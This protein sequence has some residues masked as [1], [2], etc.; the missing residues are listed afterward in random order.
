MTHLSFETLNDLI[1]GRVAASD[2][3][4]VDAHLGECAECRET[5]AALRETVDDASALSHESP[6]PD[7]LWQDI[8]HSIEAGKVTPLPVAAPERSRG[9]WMTPRRI[10]AAAVVLVAASSGLTAVVM[11]R[12]A[13]WFVSAPDSNGMASAGVVAVLPVQWQ[14]AERGYL[15]SVTELRTQLEAQR[16]RLSP[17]TI[18]TIEHSLAAIDAAIAEAREALIRD[19]ASTTLS[20][21]LASNYRQKVDLL[22]RATQ[23]SAST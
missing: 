5:L 1:D 13:P 22:R 4:R 14:A 10:A 3:G 23:L 20:E 19:P 21:L 17:A 16:D 15:N 8:Q 12:T 6:A 2:G 11:Q 9:W 7:G 18:A